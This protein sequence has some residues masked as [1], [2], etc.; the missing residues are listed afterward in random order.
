MATEHTLYNLISF[1]S[2]EVCCMALG[3]V[4][5]CMHLYAFRGH[6]KRRAVPLL[7]GVFCNGS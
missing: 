1:K 4:H 5:L 6:L 2:V 3:V 7:G